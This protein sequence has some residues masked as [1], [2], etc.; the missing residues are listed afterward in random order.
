MR[1]VLFRTRQC[2]GLAYPSAQDHHAPGP[3]PAG[4]LQL[5]RK[6][7][8]TLSRSRPIR[9]PEQLRDVAPHLR[10]L[11]KLKQ[12]GQF[13]FFAL[14]HHPLRAPGDITPHQR[15]PALSRPRIQPR[16]QPGLRV[17]RGRLIAGLH[18]HIQHHPDGRDEV[19]LVDVRR[20]SALGRVVAQHCLLLMTVQGLNR[21]VHIQNPR[22]VKQLL[23]GVA[24][25]P[26]EPARI[27]LR[28]AL[29][30][31]PP[32]GIL[33]AH[34]LHSQQ[35]RRDAVAPD[36]R[37]MR[38]ALMPRQHAQQQR[39]QDVLLRWCIRTAIAQRAIGHPLLPQLVG[40]Q[41]LDEVGDRPKRSHRSVRIPAHEHLAAQ[42]VHR[43]A[44]P[45]RGQLLI[46]L[47]QLTRRVNR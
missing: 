23:V 39:A 6:R 13:A 40:L 10:G 7:L 45:L 38:I 32:H 9:T 5:A 35:A 4:E 17:L 24:Q 3:A 44:G 14:Q 12:I 1:A 11:A 21:S 46:R 37:H 15:W 22:L 19:G 26:R 47:K 16:P 41:K 8:P 28:S 29:L 2:Q 33:A 31:R 36:C 43:R 42:G 34:A 30:K 27:V 18:L 20:P 25:V